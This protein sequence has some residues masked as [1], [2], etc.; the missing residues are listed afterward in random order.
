MRHSDSVP[1][2]RRLGV[3]LALVPLALLAS[4]AGDDD[5][6]SRSEP[7][8]QESVE[9]P[10]ELEEELQDVPE[11]VAEVNGEEISRA[12]FVRAYQVQAQQFGKKISDAQAEQL[13]STVADVL[14]QEELV[15]QAAAAHDLEPTEEQVDAALSE[16]AEQS[17]MST[18]DELVAAMEKQGMSSDYI[19]EQAERQAKF[20]LLVDEQLG[21]DAVS[22]EDVERAYASYAKQA[23]GQNATVQPLSKMREQIEQQLLAQQREKVAGSLVDDLRKDAEIDVRL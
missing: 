23:G 15:D 4:C 5:E 1:L 11:V 6:S 10:P 17:G 18:V 22:D 21:A 14:V 12:E 2:R 19:E 16:A 9:V 8:S 7:S 3:V 20:D 13:R